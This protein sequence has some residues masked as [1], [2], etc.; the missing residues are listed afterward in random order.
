MTA[1]SKQ[2]PFKQQGSSQRP[3]SFQR[4]VCVPARALAPAVSLIQRGL[5]SEFWVDVER[6]DDGLGPEVVMSDRSGVMRSE[7]GAGPLNHRVYRAHIVGSNLSASDLLDHFRTD[8]NAFSPTS[9]A[10]FDP[11][12]GPAGMRV[13]DELTVRLPGPW[14]GPVVV[15]ES[16]EGR[17]RFE[18]R[19]GHME[20]GWI[21]F[22]SMAKNGE[23]IFQIE[24]LARSGDAVFDTL[25]HSVKLGRLVQTEMWIRVLE[26]AMAISGGRLRGRPTVETTIYRDPDQ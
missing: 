20:A 22:T 18:T 5:A 10:V 21:E 12:P 13:G 24:S 23:T 4:L 16:D 8:P 17:V 19:E 9:F 11:D 7:D 1:R 14:D 2:N 15:A 6:E 26:A 3:G 25:Y